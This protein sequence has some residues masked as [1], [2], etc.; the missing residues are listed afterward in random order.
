MKNI[1]YDFIFNKYQWYYLQ[2]ITQK[3]SRVIIS[4]AISNNTT[5]VE[6]SLKEFLY[7]P[8]R[9]VTHFPIMICIFSPFIMPQILQGKECYPMLDTFLDKLGLGTP[10]N[11]EIRNHI[12]QDI[13][14]TLC[15]KR[16][17]GPKVLYKDTESTILEY[18]GYFKDGKPTPK[19]L[20]KLG[21]EYS[22]E[23]VGTSMVE[24]I[25]HQGGI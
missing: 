6:N 12:I 10:P 21:L 18:L 24:I 19:M 22:K 13:I 9:Q 3:Q 15:L 4:K 8:K 25:S 14:N 20:R 7:F 11:D 1:K 2:L 16:D 23:Q 17:P 5:M